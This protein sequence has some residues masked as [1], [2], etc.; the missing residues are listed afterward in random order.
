VPKS[1]VYVNA[2]PVTGAGKVDKKVLTEQYGSPTEQKAK[3]G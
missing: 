2:L 1:V 3:S